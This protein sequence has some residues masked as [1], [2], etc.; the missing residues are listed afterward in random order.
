[1][2]VN[3]IKLDGAKVKNE[4]VVLNTSFLATTFRFVNTKPA[5][6]KNKK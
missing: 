4:K 3:N 1:V 5:E 6:T 2:N